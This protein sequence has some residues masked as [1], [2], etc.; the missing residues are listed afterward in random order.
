M[1][2]TEQFSRPDPRDIANKIVEMY[3]KHE[4]NTWI[5]IDSSEPGLIKEMR[6]RFNESVDPESND[7][8]SH[9]VISV[10]F[11]EGKEMLSNLR[12]LMYKELI[13]IPNEHSDLIKGLMTAKVDNNFNLK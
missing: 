5:L 4:M 12:M 10:N 13:A 2:Y 9:K 7:P 6:I 3:H 1:R 8:N 11:R